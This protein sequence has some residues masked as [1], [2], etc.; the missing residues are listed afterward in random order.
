MTLPPL[1]TGDMANSV[2][3]A[4]GDTALS[5][6]YPRGHAEKAGLRNRDLLISVDG[7]KDLL[8]EADLLKYIHLDRPDARSAEIVVIRKG[9]QLPLTLR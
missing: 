9:S 2:G 8:T 3:V 4:Q 7:R 1:P 5:I 6:S